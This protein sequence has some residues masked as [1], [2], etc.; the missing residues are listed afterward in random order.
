MKLM[1]SSLCLCIY[2]STSNDNND[3]ENNEGIDCPSNNFNIDQTMLKSTSFNKSINNL[4]E[5]PK[6]SLGRKE[7]KRKRANSHSMASS[8]TNKNKKLNRTLESLSIWNNE[9]GIYKTVSPLN[10]KE[11]RCDKNRI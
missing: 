10:R 7:T 4:V 2:R 1:N 11:R 3:Y 9:A 6:E 5:S 8:S